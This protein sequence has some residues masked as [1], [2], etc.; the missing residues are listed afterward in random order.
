LVIVGSVEHSAREWWKGAVR[1]PVKHH[2]QSK[3]LDFAH[4]GG[5][6]RFGAAK[7]ELCR[8]KLHR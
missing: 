6:T 2:Q 3:T 1:A 7:Q 4:A 5:G 8:I